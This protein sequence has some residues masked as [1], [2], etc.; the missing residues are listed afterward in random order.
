[1]M[2]VASFGGARGTEEVVGK[3]VIHFVGLIS[4]NLLRPLTAQPS[5][6]AGFS[7]LSGG[8][9]PI[10]GF[11]CPLARTP[12]AMAIA[13]LRKAAVFLTSLPKPHAAVS[14]QS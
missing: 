12:G 13:T 10:N 8:N 9:V 3:D 7:G 11:N 6:F 1:M 14:S 4:D 2:A 5:V